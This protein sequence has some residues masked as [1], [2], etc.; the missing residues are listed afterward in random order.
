MLDLLVVIWL[1]LKWLK[2]IFAMIKTWYN[3][4]PRY[5]KDD[6]VKNMKGLAATLSNRREQPKL[7]GRATSLNEKAVRSTADTGNGLIVVG[8][9]SIHGF[10]DRI[11]QSKEIHRKYADRGV[12]LENERSN[13]TITHDQV[14]VNK[15]G[16]SFLKNTKSD[17][18]CVRD[19]NDLGPV[20]IKKGVDDLSDSLASLESLHVHVFGTDRSLEP[21]NT[22]SEVLKDIPKPRI[23]D[24]QSNQVESEGQENINHGLEV[25]ISDKG[26][27]VE[28]N[29][30]TKSIKSCENAELLFE[31]ESIKTLKPNVNNYLEH[32]TSS[33]SRNGEHRWERFPSQPEKRG[34]GC[35][36]VEG[37]ANEIVG[38][39]EQN[40]Y[41]KDTHKA[42]T[43]QIIY[44]AN[45]ETLQF[46]Q[47]MKV[48]PEVVDIRKEKAA[49]AAATRHIDGKGETFVNSEYMTSISM[50]HNTI[51]GTCKT[52]LDKVECE[53]D[54]KIIMDSEI[55]E[56]ENITMLKDS[57]AAKVNV[58]RGIQFDKHME[59]KDPIEK[60]RKSGLPN[61]TELLQDII[62][63]CEAASKETIT[64][65]IPAKTIVD[66]A[67]YLSKK[68][69]GDHKAVSSV[70]NQTSICVKNFKIPSIDP[71]ENNYN[72]CSSE[73]RSFRK[74]ETFSPTVE[75][76]LPKSIMK[77][78]SKGSDGTPTHYETSSC[79]RVAPK[80]ETVTK[81]M[82][83]QVQAT[84]L[85]SGIPYSSTF[86]AKLESPRRCK[87]QPVTSQD[88]RLCLRKFSLD[89]CDIVDTA[90][91]DMVALQDLREE[92]SLIKSVDSPSASELSSTDDNLKTCK[93]S[94][95]V[96]KPEI[97]PTDEK[98]DTCGS[99]RWIRDDKSE[100]QK[101]DT[102][103]IIIKYRGS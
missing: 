37:E 23:Y 12:N 73:Y 38:S 71:A 88:I 4:P 1:M 81:T 44:K 5:I 92:H 64:L 66:D 31:Q 22:D 52:R 97:Y 59:L 9:G 21:R 62:T 53:N 11:Q 72:T 25:P 3:R 36:S 82:K 68:E 18:L 29:R 94:L 26:P 19:F 55:K 10:K 85:L 60:V 58:T 50:K 30:E 80:L 89:T 78:Q 8:D 7:A 65:D 93:S 57:V 47:K 77:A 14:S 84:S 95:V 35:T 54:E 45:T 46:D 17:E 98:F 51:E 39:S 49:D 61:M 74:T 91:A 15:E 33:C 56:T 90:K 13:Q 101:V 76:E 86:G 32:K 103:T 87:S 24:N 100:E 16:P 70:E 40:I 96:L 99:P 79:S 20:S 48:H 75:A 6:R 63:V 2:M 27:M 41:Y 28:N 67:T 42:L 69:M 34:S 43:E 102:C 83:Q